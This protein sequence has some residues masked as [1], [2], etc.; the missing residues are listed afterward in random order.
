MTKL[1]TT[2]LEGPH[3]ERLGNGTLVVAN[4]K[5]LHVPY[6]NG[7]VPDFLSALHH[8]AKLKK[9]EGAELLEAEQARFKDLFFNKVVGSKRFVIIELEGRDTAGKT[10]LRERIQAPVNA[11]TKNFDVVGF[12]RPSQEERDH[13]WLWKYGNKDKL[14]GHGQMRVWERGPSER[15]LVER[16]RL[17][18]SQEALD[19][20]YEELNTWQWLLTRQGGIYIK[21]WLDITKDEQGKRLKKREA[22]N[23][24]K[25]SPEDYEN[26]KA[27][28]KY[29]PNINRMFHWIGTDFAPYYI[30]AG[31]NK[32]HC[33]VSALQVINCRLQAEF[34]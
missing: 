34:S 10:G 1:H 32:L 13:F 31:N 5:R 14:P 29:T 26:R 30:L 4:Q 20:S 2:A 18:D 21:L 8:S 28:H 15:L 12:S 3:F 7:L 19:A 25:I 9:D 11:D 22:D 6:E 27:W 17:L 16:V 33:R 23:T 24:Q